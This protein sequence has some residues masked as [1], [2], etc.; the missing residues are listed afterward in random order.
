MHEIDTTTG[1]TAMAY[2]GETPWH[3][4]GAQLGDNESLEHWR[5]QAGLDWAVEARPVLFAGLCVEGANNGLHTIPNR[6]VLVRDDTEAALSIVSDR[7]QPVQPKQI[8]EFYRD[9]TE[10][11]GYKLETA[12]ALKEGR[13]IWALANCHEAIDLPGDDRVRSYLLLATSFDGSMATQARFTS[14]RVVCNNTLQMS[15]EEGVADVVVPHSTAFD[16]DKVKLDL[17][18]G[19]AWAEFKDNAERLAMTPVTR[20]MEFA[21]IM[22]VYMGLTSEEQVKQAVLDEDVK[23]RA[24]KIMRRLAS[25]LSNSPGAL[26]RSSAGTAWGLLNAI[27]YDVDHSMPARNQ[28]NRLDSAWF[29]RGAAL[30]AHAFA[31]VL[32]SAA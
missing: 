4:L 28:G 3:G 14:V 13:K 27:T 11:F 8:I 24:D 30:K 15:T 10:K 31:T 16:A 26:M 20:E 18:I 21:A 7:Y 1:R 19:V 17:K 22:N 5:V 32:A 9:L 25:H 6:K 2:R 12:G 29:G 23:K